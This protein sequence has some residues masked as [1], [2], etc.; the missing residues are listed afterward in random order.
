MISEK[1]SLGTKA[2]FMLLLGLLLP[3]SAWSQAVSPVDVSFDGE[4]VD[5]VRDASELRDQIDRP[6]RDL[7]DTAL[8]FSNLG[9][10]HARVGCAAFD[11]NGE[12]VGR[13]LM[14]VP[15]RGLRFALASDLS[16][17]VDFV[18]HV[19]C[20]TDLRVM[21]SAILLAPSSITDLSAK[22]IRRAGVT[23]FPVVATY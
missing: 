20:R 21:G 6:D 16:N 23:I 9:Q 22:K 4:E 11:A 7:V 13:I 3:V 8:V 1:N 19:E 15:A 17:S 10:E 14:R 12:T 5:I 18:G 2:L